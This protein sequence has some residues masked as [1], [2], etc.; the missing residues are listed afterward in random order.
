MK[1][2]PDDQLA[3]PLATTYAGLTE[4]R[5][6][7]ILTMIR[8]TPPQKLDELHSV[9]T[10]PPPQGLSAAERSFYDAIVEVSGDEPVA[11][12]LTDAELAE[13]NVAAD[14]TNPDAVAKLTAAYQSLLAVRQNAVA[15]AQQA[16]AD[17]Q[18]KMA[19]LG[20]TFAGAA[21][22]ANG[23]TPFTPGAQPVKK[24]PAT[25]GNAAE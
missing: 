14:P 11:E 22:P 17:L 15:K 10:M 3:S 1:L 25:N 20:S 24:S 7:N 8:A 19:A 9:F 21:A 12:G 23:K 2:K 18:Q 13:A 6:Q 16:L 4:E 5:K